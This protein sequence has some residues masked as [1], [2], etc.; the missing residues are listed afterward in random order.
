MDNDKKIKEK[1]E[2]YYNESEVGKLRVIKEIDDM[3]TTM[4]NFEYNFYPDN[5]DDNF[6]FNISRRLEFFSF[7]IIV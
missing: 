4:D 1:Y 3:K 2:E 5:N 6:M 7:E